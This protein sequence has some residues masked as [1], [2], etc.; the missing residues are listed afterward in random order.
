MDTNEHNKTFR[1]VLEQE[2]VLLYEK[3]F[4]GGLISPHTRNSVDIRACLHGLIR[5]IQRG[6]SLNNYE[7]TFIVNDNVVYNF[8]DEQ[9]KM[10]KKYEPFGY[11]EMIYNPEPVVKKI[12]DKEIRGV[13]CKLSL[14]INENLIVEREFY[15]DNFNPNCRWSEDL[16]IIMNDVVEKIRNKI[17]K[18]DK[19]NIWDD[20]NIINRTGMTISQIRALNTNERKYWLRRINN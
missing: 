12:E 6:L 15:V 3:I 10:L 11:D 20:Y 14:Y 13:Y 17:I 19:Q 1:F 5:Q 18:K 9:N 16:I 7:H 4:D 8:I 2:D